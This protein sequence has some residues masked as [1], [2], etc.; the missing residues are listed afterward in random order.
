MKEKK[1]ICQKTILFIH[2]N[3]N[4]THCQIHGKDPNEDKNIN[5]T[6][7]WISSQWHTH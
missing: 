7:Q 2:Y 3:T 1:T 5:A 6:V 4:L